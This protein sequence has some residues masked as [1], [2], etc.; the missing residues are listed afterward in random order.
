MMLGKVEM[1]RS[2][3]ENNHV[4]FDI[5]REYKPR[6]Y[7]RIGNGGMIFLHEDHCTLQIIGVDEI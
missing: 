2:S 6:D 3:K 5:I 7:F 1:Y 4:A